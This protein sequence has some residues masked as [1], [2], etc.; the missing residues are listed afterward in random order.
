MVLGGALKPRLA[1]IGAVAGPFCRLED[2]D[3]GVFQH[4]AALS[5]PR[6]AFGRDAIGRSGREDRTASGDPQPRG[7]LTVA[8]AARAAGVP[9]S[10]VKGWIDRGRLLGAADVESVPVRRRHRGA[11]VPQPEEIAAALARNLRDLRRA[12]GLSLDALAGLARVSRGMLLQIEGQR[13]N[14]SLATLVRIAD[15]LD[16]SVSAL[17]DLGAVV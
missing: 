15:A 14:P 2:P 11:R 1:P 4:A 16:V 12:R 13:V 17:L 5:E 3:Q 7:V 6:P 9:C 8:G 10:T